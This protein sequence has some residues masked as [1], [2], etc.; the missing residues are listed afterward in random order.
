MNVGYIRVSTAEQK[1]DRQE[2]IM[3]E[4]GVERLFIDKMSGKDTNR[5]ELQKMLLFV[6]DGDTVIVESISRF[7]RNT[8]DL[9]ELIEQLEKKHVTFKSVKEN[10]DTNTSAGRFMLTIFGAVA[11]LER[12]YIKERQREGI[13]IAKKKGVYRGR[14]KIEV[15]H[16]EITYT[17]WRAGI[18][19]TWKAIDMLKI[20]KSTFYRRVKEYEKENM[21]G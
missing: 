20:S 8:R 15:H 18:I 21:I 10:I 12:N 1:I 17:E 5:D 9:L 14:Q 13:E 3:K 2:V 6:R 11:E 4:L 19:P 16:F 7:A